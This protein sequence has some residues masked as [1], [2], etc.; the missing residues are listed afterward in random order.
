[1]KKRF[2]FL[3]F[4]FILLSFSA[5]YALTAGDIAIIAVNTDATKNVVFVA[6][7]DIPASTDISFTDNAWDATTP[8]WRTGE[9]TIVW[10]TSSLVTKGTVVTITLGSPYTVDVG[11]VTNNT[12]FNLSTSG[13]QVLAYE[14]TTAPTTNASSL[15]LFA[16]STE[17]FAWGDTSNTS[18]YPTA[19]SGAYVAM[20]TSTTD[21]DNSY[22]ANGSSSQTSVSV[23]GTKTVLLALFTDSSKYYT[24]TTGPLTLPTYT[25]T[26]SSGS[27]APTTQA[28]SITFDN[29][30]QTQMDVNW[31]SGN[32]EKRIVIINTSNSFT[33]PTDGT[34]P[35]DNAV[36][37]GSGEQVVYNNSG[38]SVTVSSLTAGTTYWFRAYE[39]NGSGTGTLYL[40]DT[41][42]NNP[43]SQATAAGAVAPT[44]TTD[45][46]SSIGVYTAS[47]GGEVTYDGGA[48]V[49]AR[50]VC[51]NTTGSPTLSDSYTTDGTGEGVFTSSLTTL[52]ANQLY[53]VRAYATNSV[54]TSYGNEVTFTTLKAEPTNHVSS[55]AVGTTTFSEIPLTWSDAAKETPDGY[56]IKGSDVS[57]GDIVAPSD[58]TAESNGTLVRNVSQGIG[59]WTFTGLNDNTTY[60]FKIYPYTNYGSNINYKTD[61]TVPQ[62]SGATL[63]AQDLAAGDVAIIAF[64]CDTPDQFSFVVLTDI[65]EGT[66]ISF[67][68]NGWNDLNELNSSEGTVIW[69]APAGGIAK[70]TVVIVDAGWTADIGTVE[71]SGSPAFSTSGDQLIAYQ[72]SYTSP[73]LLYAISTTSWV[74][75]G[76]IASTT[77]YLPTGLTDGVT[78]FAFSTNYDNGY[79][80]VTSFAGTNEQIL[81]SIANDANWTFSDAW[82]TIPDWDF[83]LPVE[84][85]SFTAVVTSQYFVTLKWTTQSETNMQGYYV[86]RNNVN[87]LNSAFQI[88]SLIMATNTSNET[89]YAFTDQEVEPGNTYF[90]WLQA[91]ELNGESNFH[92]PISVVINNNNDTP[93]PIIPKV[94]EL[95]D[96]YPNPF[97]PRTYIPYTLKEAGL[98]KIEIFNLKGQVIWSETTNHSA[99][100]YFQTNW[101]GKDV[102]GNAVS[103][104]VYYYRMTSSKYTSSKKVVLMK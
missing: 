77:T 38:S 37:G 41:A 27:S 13:D 31:S 64:Q 75:S 82:L 98:V 8:A 29:I 96:A 58:Y 44:V 101:D 95:R 46:I 87:S 42:T 28:S 74:T 23:S 68:D 12:G 53:Y 30:Q 65:D 6:L 2:Y 4:L 88:P 3:T 93:T 22:F 103:S 61:G 48:T 36:Y 85:S 76:A 71:T 91:M 1:M 40:T 56:L 49:S 15:W 9:G 5:T 79:Y 14:G 81:T 99:A 21:V 78:A 89:S 18:D 57:Y 20:T 47:G 16:Y 17:S 24:N 66:E 104:G 100:G 11:S 7:T 50:G 35:S 70:Y 92:G 34:D 60:Y 102:N 55:F 10:S 54:D 25:I 63:D 43:N 52:S 73:T 45:A 39:Y 51:W 26:V 72:G 32:G 83:T 69:T 86:L 97:N 94:T 84:L 67:T 80:N 19:L 59:S 90:Y 62:V 33:N